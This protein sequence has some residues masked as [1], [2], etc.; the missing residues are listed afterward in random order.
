VNPDLFEIFSLYY[1]GLSPGGEVRFRNANQVAKLYNWTAQMLLDFLRQHELHP[2]VVLNTDFPLA[3]HQVD[4][5]LAVGRENPEQLRERAQRIYEDFVR[6]A[7]QR[8]R[9]WLKEIEEERRSEQ[10]ARR[11]GPVSN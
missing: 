5:Q 10:E 4:L 9:D 6:V 1:L 11:A 2:D 8:K 7:G 3:S